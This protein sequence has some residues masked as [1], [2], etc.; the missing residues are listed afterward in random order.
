MT[1]PEIPAIPA[2]TATP[3]VVLVY[4]RKTG[5][6]WAAPDD[7][8]NDVFLHRSNIKSKRNFLIEGDRIT[9]EWGSHDGKP[10]ALNIQIVARQTS[11]PAVQ[12]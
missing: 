3:A 10:C 1:N 12:S 11:D 4:Y 6:G 7:G 8:S 9:F 2:A 5:H